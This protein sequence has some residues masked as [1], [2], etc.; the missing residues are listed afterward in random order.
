[1]NL[2]AWRIF[3]RRHA[4]AAFTGEGAKRFG[5]RWNS[6]GSSVVYVASSLSL[7]ALEMLVHLGRQA[8]LGSYSC[9]PVTFSA[10][11]VE[12]VDPTDLPSDWRTQPPPLSTQQLGDAWLQRASSAVLRVPSVI[13]PEEWNYLLNPAHRDFRRVRIGKHR[14]FR[15]D[16]R[17]AH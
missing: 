1:M 7:A 16:S 3:N 9:A 5:G 8:V 4:R 11:L 2:V 17:L 15:F 13:V 12:T 6:R 14:P 10:N